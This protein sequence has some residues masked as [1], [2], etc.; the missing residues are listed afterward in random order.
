[1]CGIAGLYN[2]GASARDERATVTAMR[3]AMSHRG[4]DDAGLWAS[5]D[6]R[7]VLAHRRLSIVDLSAA[8]HQP[9]SNEDGSVWIT[10]NGEIYNHADLRPG[11]ES[12][13]HR[14]RSRTDTEAIVHQYE[15]TAEDCLSSLDGMFALGIWDAARDRLRA[16]ARSPGQEAALLH[17][18]RRPAAVRVRDQGAARASRRAARHRSRGA[19]PLP[20]VRQRPGAVHAVS[21]HQEAAGRAPADLRS[22]A[23]TCASS[24]T[25]R[26]RPRRPGRRTSARPRPS[27]ACASCCRPRSRS[28]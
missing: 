24:A 27:R 7:V 11:L 10:F 6:G 12:K 26:L 20:D 18:H 22:P 25:G 15:E 2:F 9:M 4:P 3:D 28:A 23:A 1:M 21:R 16:R 14:F 17:G 5:A 13:G 8:G 19:Q